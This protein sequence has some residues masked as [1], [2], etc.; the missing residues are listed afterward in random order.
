[1][2]HPQHAAIPYHWLSSVHCANAGKP[3]DE[4]T[5]PGDLVLSCDLPHYVV[6]ILLPEDTALSRNLF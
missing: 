2:L 5:V 4:T 3:Q 1:M 6:V